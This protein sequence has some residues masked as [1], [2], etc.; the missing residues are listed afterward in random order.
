[1]V[2][3]SCGCFNEENAEIQ[4]CWQLLLGWRAGEPRYWLVSQTDLLLYLLAEFSFLSFRVSVER[5]HYILAG[6]KQML[7][8]NGDA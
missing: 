4:K 7:V 2:C 8:R 3:I 5:A 6:V 1:M